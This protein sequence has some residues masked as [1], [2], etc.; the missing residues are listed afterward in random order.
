MAAIDDDIGAVHIARL[1]AGEEGD[2]IGD[3][4]RLAHAPHGVFL[5]HLAIDIRLL[6]LNILPKSAVEIDRPR[7]DRV[8]ANRSE[9]HTSELQSQFQLVCR[10][11]LEKKKRKHKV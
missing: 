5:D 10:L 2:H 8:D 4:L 9:E 6:A 3:F 7:A 11:L 1:R